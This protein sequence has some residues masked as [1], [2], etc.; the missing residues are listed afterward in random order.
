MGMEM[1]TELMEKFKGNRCQLEE[2][3]GQNKTNLN[4]TINNENVGV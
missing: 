1:Q 4:K 2:F 3:L